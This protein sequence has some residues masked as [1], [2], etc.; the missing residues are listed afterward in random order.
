LTHDAHV[1]RAYQRAEERLRHRGASVRRVV[2]DY[3]L[4]REYQQFLQA[5][6][7]GRADSDGRPDRDAEEIAAWAREHDLPYFDGSVHF[8][9]ARLEYEDRDREFRHEDIEVVT[10]HYRG[11][12]AAGT[13]RAGFSAYG[14]GLRISTSGRSGR[15]ARGSRRGVI[16]EL[17]G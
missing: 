9:D 2:L 3:E 5:R 13:V 7:R 15:S 1:Y 14:I 4:K 12:H 8:P 10:P 16:E 17:L 11:A 6:N